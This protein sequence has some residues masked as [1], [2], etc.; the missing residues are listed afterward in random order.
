MDLP[1]QWN[2]IFYNV[3]KNIIQPQLQS[4]PLGKWRHPGHQKHKTD[5][6]PLQSIQTAPRWQR[7]LWRGR[8]FSENDLSRV[9]AHLNENNLRIAG[10][11]S[12]RDQLGS[13]AFCF[14]PKNKEKPFL[15]CTGPVDGNHH[16]TRALRAESSHVLA[17]LTFLHRLEPFI[18]NSKVI[19]PVHTDCKTLIN[20][21]TMSHINRPSL[22]LGDHMD[23]IYEIRNIVSKSNFQFDFRFTQAIKKAEFELKSQEEKLVQQMHVR[24]YGYYLQKGFVVPRHFSDVLPGADITLIANGKP[25]VSNIGMSLQNLE[26]KQLREAYFLDRL[27]IDKKP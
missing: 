11:G 17:A 3:I 6:T 15:T 12:V 27:N 16:H 26:R 8:V 5:N 9:I 13:F 18:E 14:A 7:K 25:I 22:V 24:A 1:T 20:R 23:L 21:V 4:T 19:I 10:D 2:D